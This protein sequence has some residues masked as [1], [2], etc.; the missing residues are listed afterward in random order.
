[1][2]GVPG[3]TFRPSGP[4][5]GLLA[6]AHVGPVSQ[7]K[8][9]PLICLSSVLVLMSITS[10]DLLLRSVKYIRPAALSTAAISNE[11]VVPVVTL[12]MEIIAFTSMSRLL[13]PPP[14]PPHAFSSRQAA[15]AAVAVQTLVISASLFIA[16]MSETRISPIAVN[17]PSAELFALA[18][19]SRGTQQYHPPRRHG[20]LREGRM[21]TKC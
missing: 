19:S 12:G 13:P 8:N 15:N 16:L 9:P 6:P 21:L 3:M 14:P 17:S 20:F 4:E 11:K 18:C 7:P 2:N 5:F 1:M 10:T